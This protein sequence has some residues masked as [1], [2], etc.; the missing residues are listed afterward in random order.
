MR[1]DTEETVPMGGLNQRTCRLVYGVCGAG[2]VYVGI[3]EGKRKQTE[4][5]SGVVM[6][7]GLHTHIVYL[8]L[9]V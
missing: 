6:I 5:K 7:E 1:V 2:Y 8:Y 4:F 3:G 9:C